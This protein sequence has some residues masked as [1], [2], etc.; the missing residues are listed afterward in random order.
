AIQDPLRNDSMVSDSDAIVGI[1]EQ[2]VDYPETG[3]PATPSLS[4]WQPPETQV[5]RL[6]EL[7]RILVAR[8]PP[9]R[10][11]PRAVLLDEPRRG[12]G[13]NDETAPARQRSCRRTDRARR[14]HRGLDP[15]WV[16]ALHRPEM[17][18]VDGLDQWRSHPHA[19]G[20]GSGIARAAIG[21]PRP[22]T[23]VFGTESRKRSVLQR[24]RSSALGSA[25]H[26][27]LGR[28]GWLHPI[29]PR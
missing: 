27:P 10:S 21:H 29:Q 3:D 22:L 17:E 2:H 28:P 12:F 13:R 26:L 4:T 7:D 8:P 1:D 20:G 25:R 11:D 16:S 9:P 5:R 15:R 24:G 23:S 18:I 14:H 19:P 6:L